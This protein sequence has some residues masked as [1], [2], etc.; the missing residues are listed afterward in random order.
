ML[1]LWVTRLM[2]GEG[3]QSNTITSGAAAFARPKPGTVESWKNATVSQSSS[4]R[5]LSKDLEP[6]PLIAVGATARTEMLLERLPYMVHISRARKGG[7]S[8]ASIRDM[9]KVTAF[10]GI[11][12]SD[13][14]PDDGDGDDTGVI[15]EE[16]ATDKP[17][18]GKSPRKKKL[19]IKGR[20]VASSV[21]LLQPEQKL[22]P[23]D[24]DIE[25]D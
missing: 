5:K 19:L 20:G 21:P 10:R 17:V 22:V 16:W 25:D 11:G 1:D 13:D 15:Q 14:T 4:P 9:E 12:V 23:S 18:E 2:R 8:T 7:S 3:S 24:D 6:A